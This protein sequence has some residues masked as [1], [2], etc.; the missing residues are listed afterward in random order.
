MRL[1]FAK[2]TQP[3][4]MFK[5]ILSVALRNFRNNRVFSVINILGLSIGIS[6][7]LVIFLIVQY[8]NSFDQFEKNQNRIFRVVSDYSFQGDTGHTRGVP[9]PLSDAIQKDIS[10]IDNLVTFRYYS[11]QK[12]SIPHAA[13]EKPTLFK[14]PEHIIF[15]DA[16]YF[17]MLPYHWIAGNKLASTAQEG[18][19]VLTVSRAKLYFPT[20]TAP[21][22]I[23]QTIVYDDT[24]AAKVSGIVADLEEQGNTDFNFKEFISLNTILK[25]TKLRKS[26]YWDQ[27]G[28]T[29]S[30]HQVYVQLGA[31][32]SQSSIEK[33]LKVIFDKN[34]GEDAKKNHYTW[35]YALQPLSDIHFNDHYGNFD[36]PMASRPV[37]LGLILV[38]AFLILIASINFIN[39]TTAQAAQRAKEIGVRKTLGSSKGQLIAQFLGETLLVTGLA[40]LL[41]IVLTPALLKIFSDFIPEGVHFSFGNPFV[42]AFIAI[43]MISV[44]LLAGLYPAWLLSSSNILETLKNRAYAGTNRT[45]T[46]WLRKGLTVSQFVIAQFFVIGAVLVSKQIHFMLN[47]DLGFSKQAILSMD[48][49]YTDTSVAHKRYFQD[50][51]KKIPGISMTTIANDKP[52]SNGWWTTAMEYGDAKTPLQTNVEMKACDNNY[53]SLLKIPLLAGRDLLPS[54]TTS[55]LLINETYLHL[56]GFKQPAEALNKMLKFD[57]K[58]IPIVGVFRNFNAHP[59][60]YKIAPMALCRNASSSSVVMASLS[61]DHTNWPTVIDKI[62]KLYLATYPG[63]EFKYKFLDESI[64]EAYGNVQHTSQLLNWAMG[65]TIFIS[66]LGLLGLVMYTTTQ[67]TKEIGIRKVLG[68]SVSQI[69]ALLS[70]DFIKLVAIAFLIATPLAWWAINA[71]L[72]DFV[73]RT[74]VSWW[75]FA[76]SG[77]GMIVIALATLSV[78]TIRSA[79]ANPVNNLRSE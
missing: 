16:H 30:D 15:A 3:L 62:K 9:V 59:L 13:A 14:Q 55:E 21:Q 40:T 49:P 32:T 71:W 79:T 10:G 4:R 51:L 67:R 66:C 8:S 52:S 70:S 69:M 44:S 42:I 75:V 11:A 48:F 12:L 50:E 5:N 1:G 37:L 22:A 19:V 46:A 31:N 20:L 36:A 35:S 54:D 41:S 43:L 23:G 7:S 6:A 76:V 56:L 33:G 77:V 27:W 74:S 17:D 58:Q 25:N 61:Q 29:T 65:L 34:K 72:D 53:L 68:A 60:N 38:A 28:S 26:F 64:S 73:F 18:Q 63:E 47:K 57:E 2:H 78:Q 39:L 45:R 24:L